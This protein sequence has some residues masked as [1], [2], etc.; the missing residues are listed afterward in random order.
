MFQWP[1]SGLPVAFQWPLS[2]CTKIQVQVQL[3]KN[4]IVLNP[5]PWSLYNDLE[6][7]QSWTLQGPKTLQ[8]VWLGQS[9]TPDLGFQQASQCMFPSMFGPLRQCWMAQIKGEY[10]VN[11]ISMK[12]KKHESSDH[13]WFKYPE[14]SWLGATNPNLSRFCP[15][16]PMD[17]QP[18]SFFWV[19]NQEAAMAAD[20]PT[21]LS[22][23]RAQCSARSWARTDDQ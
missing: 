14:W 22:L 15:S 7:D 5:G 10:W 3:S 16:L 17:P 9:S 11:Q 8:T 20:M 18:G 1:S 12:R 23:S 19:R 13:K 21:G 2:H 4:W 6:I